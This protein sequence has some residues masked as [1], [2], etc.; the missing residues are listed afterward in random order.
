M[1]DE[2]GAFSYKILT[3]GNKIKVSTVMSLNKAKIGSNYY[4]VLK[5]FFDEM[6]KKNTE[7]IILV[8]S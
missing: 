2:L 5:Q 8:K 3:S 1:L 6:V 4:S 7:K